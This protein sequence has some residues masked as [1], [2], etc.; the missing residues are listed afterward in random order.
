M[1][2]QAK[3]VSAES[4]ET[5]LWLWQGGA[6]PPQSRPAP[7]SRGRGI[8][9]RIV[10]AGRSIRWIAP[11]GGLILVLLAG[12]FMLRSTPLDRRISADTR[13]TSPQPESTLIPSHSLISPPSIELPDVRLD[14]VQM[15]TPPAAQ[16]MARPAEG[17]TVNRRAQRRSPTSV[18]GN[19]ASFARRGSP[20]LIPGVLTPPKDQTK[21]TK[22]E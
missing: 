8:A 16:T 15:P 12:S 4:Q 9:G 11:A 10:A 21:P 5:G 22:E 18:R 3:S 19:S 20:V 1:L 6:P 14:Q 7:L 2:S 17:Q 13:A